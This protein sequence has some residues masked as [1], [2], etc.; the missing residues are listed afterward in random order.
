MALVGWKV[1]AFD[2]NPIAVAATRGNAI[3]AG[4]A[5]SIRVEESGV[6]EEGWKIP[7]DAD[8]IIWNLPYLDPA[9]GEGARLGPLEEA[10]LG[11][12]G[13]LG[14][15]GIL[16]DSLSEGESRH[17][18]FILL[19]RTDPDSLS[20]PGDWGLKGWSSRRLAIER[21]GDET[22]EAVAFWKPGD[23]VEAH[24]LEE[25]YSTMDDARELPAEGWQRIR[26]GIQQSGRG[27]RGSQWQSKAGDLTATWSLD[28]SVL[29]DRS[30]GLLQVAVGA[31][32]ANV[33]SMDL[34]WPN[35][36]LIDGRKA[37]GILHSTGA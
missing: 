13:E 8:I 10:A 5:E 29:N 4:V 15:S 22:L 19:F 1:S 2:I 6:G 9:T 37:G 20:S 11:D 14:W 27:R 32:V 12:E 17:K 23:T 7:S 28:Q 25:S 35:D 33:L 31:C 16:L 34:K 21:V 24:Y 36:L 3:E 30:P 18:T 26:A